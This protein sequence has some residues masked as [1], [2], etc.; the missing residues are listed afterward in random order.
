MDFG[1]VTA[2][3][4]ALL[5]AACLAGCSQ[6]QEQGIDGLL[7]LQRAVGEGSPGYYD[8]D[9]DADYDGDGV[10]DRED[11][12][13]ADPA[14]AHAEGDLLPRSDDPETPRPAAAAETPT[15]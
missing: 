1:K 15:E 12:Y 10:P 2:T 14:S 7:D 13:P 5:T 4:A 8:A 11:D 9:R 3:L 6:S